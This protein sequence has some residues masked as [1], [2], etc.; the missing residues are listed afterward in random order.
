[1]KTQR[2]DMTEKN[3]FTWTDLAG[4]LLGLFIPLLIAFAAGSVFADTT[5]TYTPDSPQVYDGTSDITVTANG[6]AGTFNWVF[7]KVNGNNFCNGCAWPAGTTGTM[8]SIY[9]ANFQTFAGTFGDIHILYVDASAGGYAAA[10]TN[11]G[12]TVTSCK[13]NAGWTSAGS[14][15]Q[16]YELCDTTCPPPSPPP[17]SLSTTTPPN[18]GGAVLSVLLSWWAI[19]MFELALIFG[20]V[21]WFVKSLRRGMPI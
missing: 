18:G 17:P 2:Q 7:F 3:R 11:A 12:S 19:G 14:V 21:I 15:E 5:F 8:N 13:A 6:S 4:L 20:V 16:I 10:C 1:M 9:G